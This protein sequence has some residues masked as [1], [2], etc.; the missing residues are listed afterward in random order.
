MEIF[1]P[2]TAQA[3]GKL[4]DLATRIKSSSSRPVPMCV[5]ISAFM[6][7]WEFHTSLITSEK[8]TIALSIHFPE[9]YFKLLL[10]PECNCHS[11]L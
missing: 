5:P 1:L 2:V 4:T 11:Q 9:Y 8:K 6:H 3:E 10:A 7:Q